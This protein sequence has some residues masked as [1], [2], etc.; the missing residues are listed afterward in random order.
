MPLVA[1]LGA[2]EIG[3][4]TARALAIRARVPT[5]RLIDERPGVA[6]GKA[7][8]LRQAGPIDASDTRIEGSTDFGAA[9]GAPVIVLADTV[10]GGEWSGDAG[11]A[12]LRR[13]AG[14][15][16]FRGSVLICAGAGH[17]GLIQLAFDEL[18]LDRS[19]VVGS[20][21][22]AFASTVR[23]LVAIEA[24]ASAWQVALTVLG[25]PP[26]HVAIPWAEA[27]VAGHSVTSLLTAPQLNLVER[28]MR[29]LWPPGPGALG[30]A[31]AVFSEAVA[32]GSRRLLSAFVLLDRDNGTKAPVCAWPVTI[33]P[34][35]LVRVTTPALTSRDRAVIDEVLGN[36][37]L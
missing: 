34:T 30:T 3:G 14:L 15:G 16:C 28:R 24:R 5:I 22:E 2:G 8:D 4:A 27:S 19:R 7:L 37:A 23:A 12:L 13:L 1:I 35:G 9:I 6:A 17:S 10:G 18:G 25:R 33:G 20:A 32:L 29:G 11:L 36:E 31:A 21:P 26:A